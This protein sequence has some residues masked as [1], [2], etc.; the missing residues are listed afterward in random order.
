MNTYKVYFTEAESA[1]VLAIL[2]SSN[3]VVINNLD[4]T[5]AS[6]TIQHDDADLIYEEL[7]Q[8]IERE[9]RSNPII[10]IRYR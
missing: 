10:T 5:G 8:R 3:D 7:L 4:A 9:V 2:D 6:I 1:A